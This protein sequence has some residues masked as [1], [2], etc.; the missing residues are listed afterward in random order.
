M[1]LDVD[2]VAAAAFEVDGI[3]QFPTGITS[4]P[5]CMLIA[6]L[7]SLSH[8]CNNSI[9]SFLDKP[10]IYDDNDDLESLN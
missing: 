7:I 8:A 6:I 3:V 2:V 1:N 10:I 4:A 9:A 5:S